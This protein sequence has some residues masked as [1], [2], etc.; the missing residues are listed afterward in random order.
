MQIIGNQGYSVDN[1]IRF[2]FCEW[3][4]AWSLLFDPIDEDEKALLDEILEVEILC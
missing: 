1:I 2:I 4:T 3:K